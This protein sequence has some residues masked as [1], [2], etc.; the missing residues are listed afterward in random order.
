MKD[1]SGSICRHDVKRV[2]NICRICGEKFWLCPM[3]YHTHIDL[4]PDC[5]I[6]EKKTR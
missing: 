6:K 1:Y 4:C 3:C 5:E 2:P